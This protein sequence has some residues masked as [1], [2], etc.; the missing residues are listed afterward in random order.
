MDPLLIG[1]HGEQSV[2]SRT[3]DPVLQL[4]LS[5]Q[6]AQSKAFR[7]FS[8]K[9]RLNIQFSKSSTVLNLMVIPDARLAIW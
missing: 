8:T 4:M 7:P 3:R 2:Q 9:A 5:L 1:S 6:L